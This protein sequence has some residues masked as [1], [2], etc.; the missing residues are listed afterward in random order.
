[1]WPASSA[2]KYMLTL[3]FFFSFLII[4]LLGKGFACGFVIEIFYGNFSPGG[5]FR[6]LIRGVWST[7]HYILHGKSECLFLQYK[8]QTTGLCWKFARPL[9]RNLNL[10]TTQMV[11][12]DKEKKWVMATRSM[13][14]Q[15]NSDWNQS[16]WIDSRVTPRIRCGLSFPSEPWWGPNQRKASLAYEW[17]N[18][19]SKVSGRFS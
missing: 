2:H 11:T 19:G 14:L 16:V 6:W 4:M 3:W 5:H 12:S 9:R 7:N 10:F 18:K 1:M 15:S 8:S 13:F 17:Q